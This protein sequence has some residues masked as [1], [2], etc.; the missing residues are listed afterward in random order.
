MQ[1]EHQR[2]QREKHPLV[3]VESETALRNRGGRPNA[4]RENKTRRKAKKQE[5]NRLAAIQQKIWDEEYITYIAA[6]NFLFKA[7]LQQTQMKDERAK[8]CRAYGVWGNPNSLDNIDKLMRCQ[9]IKYCYG[10]SYE[11]HSCLLPIPDDNMERI[12]RIKLEVEYTKRRKWIDNATM[13]SSSCPLCNYTSYHPGIFAETG[14]RG[15]TINWNPWI[16]YKGPQRYQQTS[17]EHI[18]C[19]RFHFTNLQ[20]MIHNHAAGLPYAYDQYKWAKE[21]LDYNSNGTSKV[22]NTVGYPR[23][24]QCNSIFMFKFGISLCQ[25]PIL[26]QPEEDQTELTRM[27]TLGEN[28]PNPK[29]MREYLLSLKETIF[30]GIE[31]KT[32]GL[33]HEKLKQTIVTEGYAT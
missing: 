22:R 5:D 25:I 31:T 3:Y 27:I 7:A 2:P 26:D 9:W 12:E 19:R 4:L 17:N 6:C 28:R 24:C 14:Y 32:W 20:L 13:L 16:K 33:Y 18:Y 8:M 23:I 21:N 15:N 29:N 30:K 10:L 1:A 11:L